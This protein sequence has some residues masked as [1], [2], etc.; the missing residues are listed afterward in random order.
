MST[1][2][3]DNV[4][5]EF[6]QLGKYRI[7]VLELEPGRRV[8]DI[9]EYVEN[10]TFEGFTKRG[11]RLPLPRAISAFEKVFSELEGEPASVPA[12]PVSPPVPATAA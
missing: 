9:R 1:Q 4:I 3:P 8:L 6:A 7:R 10:S 2:R 11:V 12:E 5:R